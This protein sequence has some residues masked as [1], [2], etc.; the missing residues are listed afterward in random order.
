MIW[1]NVSGNLQINFIQMQS[2]ISYGLILIATA[3]IVA[4]VY[5]LLLFSN[6]TKNWNKDQESSD[7]HWFV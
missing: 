5:G 1:L 2:G 3:S 6:M 4:I 7:V